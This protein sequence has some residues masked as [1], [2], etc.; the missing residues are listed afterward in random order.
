MP[1][2]RM[3]MGIQ[4]MGGMGRMASKSG[5]TSR[6]TLG[7]QPMNKPRGTPMTT[8]ARNP[9]K[10]RPDSLRRAVAILFRQG[11]RPSTFQKYAITSEETN[12]VEPMRSKRQ[13][14]VPR[15]PGKSEKLT[16]DIQFS[17]AAGEII[18]FLNLK[19]QFLIGRVFFFRILAHKGSFFSR[20]PPA[21]QK[22]VERTATCEDA[23]L[24]K[25]PGQ[26]LFLA[27]WRAGPRASS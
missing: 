8:A 12:L 5:R 17:L 22:M 18:G 24:W 10:A 25:A 21:R 2:Q 13:I 7:Y 23:G 27:A 14:E 3:A 9:A 19:V 6:L 11:W 15:P 1:S 4:A 20:P 16:M 26:D